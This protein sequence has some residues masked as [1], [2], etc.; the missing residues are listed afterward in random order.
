MSKYSIESV[1]EYFALV[2]QECGV[3]QRSIKE[4]ITYGSFHKTQTEIQDVA[5]KTQA[6]EF[7]GALRENYETILGAQTGLSGGQ[8]QRI[9]IARGLLRNA[10]IFLF[11]ESTSALDAKTEHDVLSSINELTKDCTK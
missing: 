10:K 4:N 3:F 1:R 9:A 7:I 6:N 8:K 5:K 2:P 11:D